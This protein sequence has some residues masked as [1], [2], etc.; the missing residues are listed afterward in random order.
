MVQQ[1]K[2]IFNIEHR[3]KQRWDLLDKLILLLYYEGT[4]FIFN[5]Y[6]S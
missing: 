3:T 5:L 6:I 4:T 2:M 1:I